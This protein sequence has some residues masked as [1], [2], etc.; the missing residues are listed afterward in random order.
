VANQQEFDAL[1]EARKDV[2]LETRKKDRKV[3]YFIHQ[4]V[5]LVVFERV[6]GA[7][8]AKEA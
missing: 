6:C 2:R 7:N 3:L 1:P 8:M 4:M 5:N